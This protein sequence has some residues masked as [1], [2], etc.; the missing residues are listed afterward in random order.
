MLINDQ[1]NIKQEGEDASDD[2]A[3]AKRSQSMFDDDLAK[4]KVTKN[5]TMSG[6]HLN[7]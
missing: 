7:E 2:G 5:C 3:P 1:S 6:M 4:L